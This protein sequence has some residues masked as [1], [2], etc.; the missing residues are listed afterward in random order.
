MGWLNV[1]GVRR[2]KIPLLWSTAGVGCVEWKI[3]HD[4]C[5]GMFCH[6]VVTVCQP[7]GWK[8]HSF[9]AWFVTLSPATLLSISVSSSFGVCVAFYYPRLSQCLNWNYSVFC[10]DL[11]TLD[12]QLRTMREKQ[13]LFFCLFVFRA[14]AV[15]T[16]G[17]HP[18]CPFG[19]AD[20]LN[21][22]HW[23]FISYLHHVLD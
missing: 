19:K 15:F 10:I 16:D 14:L 12:C 23:V 11:Y 6:H 22:L 18:V 20:W 2:E 5:W 17:L 1:T 3:F 7:G 9:R 21:R 8:V 4:N 13:F